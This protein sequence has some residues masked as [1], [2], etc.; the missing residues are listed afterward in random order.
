MIFAFAFGFVHLVIGILYRPLGIAIGV[1]TFF[2]YAYPFVCISAL[3]IK[4]F[5]ERMQQNANAFNKNNV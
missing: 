1:L 4:F 3:E 5:N 2:C